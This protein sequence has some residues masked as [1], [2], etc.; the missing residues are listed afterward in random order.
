[1][2]QKQPGL[3]IEAAAEMR[4]KYSMFFAHVAQLSSKSSFQES[5]CYKDEE[6]LIKEE[7]VDKIDN[8]EQ[9]MKSKD[10]YMKDP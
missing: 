10:E 1:M 9:F 7:P 3:N 8:D 4:L 6:K 2:P 5:H